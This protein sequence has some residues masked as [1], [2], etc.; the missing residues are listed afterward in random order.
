MGQNCRPFAHLHIL[1]QEIIEGTK[2]QGGTASTASVKNIYLSKS[3]KEISCEHA[4]TVPLL[5]IS[6]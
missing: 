2:G 4:S 3:L 1:I 6:L 5:S